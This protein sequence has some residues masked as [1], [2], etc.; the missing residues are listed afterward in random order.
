MYL[1]KPHTTLSEL[2]VFTYR[3]I[4]RGTY[5]STQSA[6]T[7]ER[8]LQ[9]APLLKNHDSLSNGCSVNDCEEREHH[10]SRLLAIR[11]YLQENVDLKVP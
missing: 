6:R 3:G 2:P 1:P 10:E 5:T 11:R 8:T 7:C 9:Q 4:N